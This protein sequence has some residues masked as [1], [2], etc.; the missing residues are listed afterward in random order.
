M[1]KE[2][3]KL[4]E[5]ESEQKTKSKRRVTVPYHQRSLGSHVVR[6]VLDHPGETKSN[7]RHLRDASRGYK[8]KIILILTVV[9]KLT[10]PRVFK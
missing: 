3:R 5:E 10:K 6:W 1:R 8:T 4:K 2:P 9:E 7:I